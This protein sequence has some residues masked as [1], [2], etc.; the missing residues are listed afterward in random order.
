M[1]TTASFFQNCISRKDSFTL[2]LRNYSREFHRDDLCLADARTSRFK[3]YGLDLDMSNLE[4]EDALIIP[5]SG[6]ARDSGMAA[7]DCH[8]ESGRL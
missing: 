3:G 1:K 4:V 7:D 8:P 6:F 2:L 5:N